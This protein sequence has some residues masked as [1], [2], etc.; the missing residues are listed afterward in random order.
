VHRDA[1]AGG[2]D[3]IDIVNALAGMAPRRSAGSTEPLAPKY[4]R[5]AR[6]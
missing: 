5:C 1:V 2:I 6:A 4:R 3:W